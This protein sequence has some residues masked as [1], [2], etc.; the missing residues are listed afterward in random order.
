LA[1]A[2]CRAPA[3]K[4]LG[5]IMAQNNPGSMASDTAQ[6]PPAML[7]DTFGEVASWLAR[8][9]LL[10]GV[11]FNYLI[12]DEAMLPKE[13]IRFFFVD[14][15]WIQSLVQG[16]CSVGNNG[17]GDTVID[18][19]MNQWVQPNQ[20]VGKNQASLANKKAAGIRNQL[21]W[22]HEAVE[23]PEEEAYLDW[24]LTGFLLRSSVVEGWR[25]LEMMAYRN[26]T[27]PEKQA[28]AEK[29]SSP[30]TRDILAAAMTDITEASRDGL[31][32]KLRD[33]LRGQTAEKQQQ[34]FRAAGMQTAED[35]SKL[36][37]EL[38]KPL[39]ALRMEQLSQDVMLGIFNGVIA[40]LVIRQPQEGLHFGLTK[41]GQSYTKTLRELGY[42]NADRAGQLLAATIDLSRDKLMRDQEQQ[43]VVKI[44]E[45]ANKMNTALSSVAQLK[46]GKFTSAE[47]A[48][49]M[50]EAAGEFTFRP[51]IRTS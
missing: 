37:V 13:S 45:L 10:Y 30:T 16:A 23:L 3:L 4:N 20:P 44:A 29:Q 14:P 42:K 12:P 21:R 33:F 6:L 47:F 36:L 38:V 48:V 41:D 39:K 25:G 28:L 27:D 35:F 1:G 11:P 31:R 34:L 32:S 15:V 2:N 8:L 51:T 40:Q 5:E 7:D 18:K 26:L 17:Y 19:A 22:Q 43:G 46:D 9:V 49:E 50:I 24:P